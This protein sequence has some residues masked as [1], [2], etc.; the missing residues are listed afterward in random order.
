MPKKVTDI[1][2]LRDYIHGV[3]DRAKHHAGNVDEIALAIAGAVIWRTDGDIK[4]YEYKGQV[5]NAL[6]TH[7]NGQKY[8]LSYNHAGQ[9]EVRRDSLRGGVLGS[10]DNSNTA[11]DVRQFFSSL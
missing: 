7:I 3:M 2:A 10:F 8:V 9:I 4:V 1:D 5:K 6:W 11:G